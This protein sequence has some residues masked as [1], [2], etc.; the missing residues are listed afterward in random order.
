MEGITSQSTRLLYV[1]IGLGFAYVAMALIG[2]VYLLFRYFAFGLRE[3]WAS[4]IVLLLGS[5]GMILMAIGILG[6]YTANIFDQV[7][8]RPLYLVQERINFD[9]P[10]V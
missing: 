7:R 3:G 2:V 5:T 8:A 9:R 4:I 1:A 10:V 6:V